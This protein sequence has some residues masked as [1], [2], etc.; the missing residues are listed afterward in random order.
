MNATIFKPEQLVQRRNV[1][2]SLFILDRFMAMSMG[3]PTAISDDNCTSV[4]MPPRSRMDVLCVAGS[5]SLETVH[6]RG[7]DA[8]VHC[9]HVIGIILQTVYSRRRVSAKVAQELID[10]SSLWYR[11]MDRH[12]GATE[13][14]ATPEHGLAIL[15]VNLFYYHSIILTTRPFFLSVMTSA[16]PREHNGHKEDPPP[17]RPHTKME[18][19]AGVC[20][21]ASYET[22]WLV[23]RA[24]EGNYLPQRDPFIL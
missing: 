3:R 24:K 15:R 2:K 17:R 9:C 4:I 5:P 21:R 12:L 14:P 10:R 8:M 6:K 7:L 23:Q 22:I 16:L 18:K 1:W 13:I 20:V 11:R 19:F